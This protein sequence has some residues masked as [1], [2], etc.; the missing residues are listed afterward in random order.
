MLKRSLVALA[1][2]ALATPLAAQ[3]MTPV[4]FSLD[5]KFEGPSAAYFAAV[6]N[7]HFAAEGLD[8][9]LAPTFLIWIMLGGVLGSKLLEGA[10]GKN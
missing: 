8:V 9:E 6:D 2:I 7:G 10:G 4:R 1:A 3:D 5:W